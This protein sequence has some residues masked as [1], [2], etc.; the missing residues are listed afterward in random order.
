MCV[1]A[2][3]RGTTGWAGLVPLVRTGTPAAPGR[4]NTFSGPC[5]DRPLMHLG[6]LGALFRHPGRPGSAR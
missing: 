3:S 6:R 1:R 4:P 2:C 5:Q